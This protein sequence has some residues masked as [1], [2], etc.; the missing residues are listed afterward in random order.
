MPAGHAEIAVR[1]VCL[2]PPAAG[3]LNSLRHELRFQN[4]Q[5]RFLQAVADPFGER[6]VD[7]AGHLGQHQRA[8]SVSV[9]RSVSGFMH[10]HSVCLLMI[11]H[12]PHAAQKLVAVRSLSRHMPG[13]H[14]R[15]DGKR[16][17]RD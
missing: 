1:A 15:H 9:H 11:E 7:H 4:Q 6:L 5:D 2:V 12:P 10:E 16:R 8:D 14:K 17:Q 13:C 3:V